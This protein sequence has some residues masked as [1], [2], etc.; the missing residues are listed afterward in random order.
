MD[1]PR[2]WPNWMLSWVCSATIHGVLI[3]GAAL[4]AIGSMVGDDFSG[5]ED[6]D[7]VVS[8]A[9]RPER[10]DPLSS[11]PVSTVTWDSDVRAAMRSAAEQKK[12]L[13]VFSTVGPSDG[14]ACLGGVREYMGQYESAVPL[15]TRAHRLDPQFDMALH[16]MGRA[17]V[18]L[19]RYDEAEIA[20]K[21]RLG[22]R[23]RSDMT[24]FYLA[25]LYGKTGRYV[26]ARK[27]WAELMEINPAFS[28][29]HFTAS[30]P[31]ADPSWLDG[32]IDGLRQANIPI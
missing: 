24:R 5:E 15:Y 14:Y 4:V 28:V 30:L 23:P 26:E 9:P 16:F 10:I 22:L 27:V 8:L 12:P 21:R 29:Q 20:F 2:P 13:L 32:V 3:L 17:L 11:A 6:G 1:S 18:A 25:C 31:Y 7:H 19:G